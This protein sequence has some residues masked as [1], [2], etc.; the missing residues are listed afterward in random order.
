[1]AERKGRPRRRPIPILPAPDT[2][3]W[4]ALATLTW[5]ALGLALK[6]GQ[7]LSDAP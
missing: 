1:M 5:L 3:A 7:C 2:A 4:A 6:V